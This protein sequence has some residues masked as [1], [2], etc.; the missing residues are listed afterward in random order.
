MGKSGDESRY[1]VILGLCNVFDVVLRKIA[2]H[3][4]EQ[5]KL[6]FTIPYPP[7]I[8]SQDGDILSFEIPIV[9]Y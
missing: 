4:G 9:C 7:G 2:L 3:L 1:F 8:R 5:L 6:L